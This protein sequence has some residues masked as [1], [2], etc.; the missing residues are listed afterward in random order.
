MGALQPPRSRV[1]VARAGL[2]VCQTGSSV[3]S[4]V[5]Y[6][7]A[8]EPLALKPLDSGLTSIGLALAVPTPLTAPDPALGVHFALV[9]NVNTWNTN[10]LCRVLPVPRLAARAVSELRRH[11]LALPRRAQCGVKNYTHDDAQ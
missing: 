3:N 7:G 10:Y 2:R 5:Y 11:E 8:E 1:V 9:E 6:S 4:G